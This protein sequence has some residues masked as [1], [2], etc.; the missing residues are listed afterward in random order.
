MRLLPAVS[1]ILIAPL[2]LICG[3]SCA[4]FDALSELANSG[5]KVSAVAIDL[6]NNKVL[7]SLNP[8]MR[9]APASVSKLIVAAKALST[10][11]A[12]QTF[13]THLYATSFPNSGVINGDLILSTEGDASLDH[14]SLI[15]LASQLHGAG[16]TRVQGSIV[17]ATA[18]FAT[19]ACETQ[20]RCDALAK[21]STAYNAPIAGLGVD[22]GAWCVEVHATAAKKPA[23]IT[24][25]E[26]VPLPIAVEGVITTAS[27]GQRANWWIDRRTENGEDHLVVGGTVPPGDFQT[28]YRAMSEPARG[29]GMVL[30]ETLRAV[31][32]NVV[33]GV[34]VR[35]APLPGSAVEL[36]RIESLSLKE[37]L[38]RMLRFSNNYVADVLTMNMAAA[39]SASIASL[40]DASV[41]LSQYVAAAN[42]D[43]A[44][45]PALYSGSGLT[46]ESQISA[47]E[48]AGM[49][50]AEHRNTR[51]FNAYYGG[52]VVPRQAPF[53]FLRGG[54]AG[55]QDRVAL[56]PGTMN[57]PRSVCGI[58]GYIRKN[59]GG[60]IA[61]AMLVNGGP[62]LLHV[63]LYK[64]ME[65]IRADV[66]VLLNNY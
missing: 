50:A 4:D 21:S 56:K 2:L 64:S 14:E 48:V 44:N 42:G 8:A 46:P 22:Y 20:D 16:I 43:P 40:A 19:L 62:R 13:L 31:G 7:G 26:G 52:L 57:D 32:I 54:S 9:L 6:D 61:F 63:P 37:Q 12:D 51:N 66:D 53:R 33:G 25:C 11:P 23:Q 45:P 49:L 28:A 10:W 34:K 17:I 59:N 35:A 55:W 36:G 47:Q 30:R 24:S 38:G 3:E 41:G 15:D 5:A 29:A 1:K 39:N 18:P 58:A 27:A 60:F 65:A